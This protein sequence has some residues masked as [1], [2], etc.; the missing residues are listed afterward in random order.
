MEKVLPVVIK[1]SEDSPQDPGNVE[2]TANDNVWTFGG[3]MQSIVSTTTI[4]ATA[5]LL[6]L[7]G[8]ALIVRLSSDFFGTYFLVQ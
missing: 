1:G 7:N 2:V 3:D 8:S 4:S 6:N 5:R